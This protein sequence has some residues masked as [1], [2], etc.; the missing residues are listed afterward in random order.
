M[1][2]PKSVIHSRQSSLS[3]SNNHEG[4]QTSLLCTSQTAIWQCLASCFISRAAKVTYILRAGPENLV[5]PRT[6]FFFQLLSCTI[7]SMSR[8]T[9]SAII[10]SKCLLNIGNQFG[11]AVNRVKANI[12]FWLFLFFLVSAVKIS[13]FASGE[14]LD[15]CGMKNVSHSWVASLSIF[16]EC[17]KNKWLSQP[18]GRHSW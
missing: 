6:L 4:F 17:L 12:L 18:L 8:G 9:F 1:K 2:P 5:S 11:P 14:K 15:I 16:D 10:T 7:Q 13:F 3:E